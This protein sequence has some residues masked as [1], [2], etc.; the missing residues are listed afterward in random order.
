MNEIK[1]TI[2]GDPVGK[3]RPRATSAGPYVRM[4]TPKK[5]AQYEELVRHCFRQS[6]GKMLSGPVC[7]EAK[8]YLQMPKSLSQKKQR[9]LAYSNCEKKPDIDNVIKIIGDALNGIAYK[10]DSSIVSVTATKQWAAQGCL[11]VS[12]NSAEVKQD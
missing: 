8:L 5:T 11:V 10:D 7:L 9:E 12:L 3:A 4:Y 1:F 2:P 6:G